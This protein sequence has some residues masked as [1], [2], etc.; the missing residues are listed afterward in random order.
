MKNLIHPLFIVLLA[1]IP[2]VSAET[3]Y[4]DIE[5]P[6]INAN[7][8]HRPYVAVWVETPERKGVHTLAFWAE[9]ADWY[10]DLRQWWRKIGRKNSPNY[11]GVSGATRKP[12][13]Y[14]LSWDGLAADGIPV[15]PGDYILHLESVR[16]QGS[17]E[18]LRQA[19]VLGKQQPQHYQLQG[20]AELGLIS[21]SI[22]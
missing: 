12:G 11:D 2:S 1:V 4:V 18:Y 20:S 17:R 8:Y 16:E 15:Q 5:V 13:S 19:I 22:K 10:K 3:L 9:Q 6:D 7:P 21:I 14:Q